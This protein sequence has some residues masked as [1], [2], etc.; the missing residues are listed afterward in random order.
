[1]EVRLPL[2]GAYSL[3]E[4]ETVYKITI[5]VKVIHSIPEKVMAKT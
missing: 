4:Y 2:K 5:E 3:L 1:M